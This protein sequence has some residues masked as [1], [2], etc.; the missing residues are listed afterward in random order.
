MYTTLILLPLV[1]ATIVL[2][3]PAW[4]S[5]A[6]SIALGG[7]AIANG[8]GAHGALENPASMMEMKRA[9]Q[10]THFRF[11]ASAEFRNS[12]DLVDVLSEDINNGLINDIQ[13]EGDELTTR[14]VQCDPIFGNANDVCIDNTQSLSD[15]AERL[16]NVAN[17]IRDES[18]D[19]KAA[20]DLGIAF[21]QTN[22]PVAVNLRVLATG[23]GF[24]TIVDSDLDYINELSTALDGNSLTLEEVQNS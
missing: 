10:R 8:K 21:T 23:S 16:F 12:G 3:G 19:I 2:S 15:L 7:S 6:R 22:Y 14:D 17:D 20:A 13:D 18:L 9:G 1:A 24:A 4:S 5:D 11:G